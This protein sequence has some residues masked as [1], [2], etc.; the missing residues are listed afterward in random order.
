MKKLTL[1][2][3]AS[4]W[5]R[6]WSMRLIVATVAYSAAAGA[7]MLLPVD[8]KPHLSDGVKAVLAGIGVALPAIA[9]VARVVDQPRL[10]PKD[11]G[12]GQ[13]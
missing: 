8:L 13:A 12:D 9:A 11:G 2:P 7:W 4:I 3:E 10:R 1:I 6:L 5:Y